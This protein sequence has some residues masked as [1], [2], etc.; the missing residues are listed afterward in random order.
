MKLTRRGFLGAAGTAT[1][2]V[3]ATGLTGVVPA[4]AADEG[5][6]AH[7]VQRAAVCPGCS[8]GCGVRCEVTDGLVSAVVGDEDH[9]LNQ[10]RHCAR[11]AALGD[12]YAVRSEETGD[13]TVNPA[14]LTTPRVRR[15]GAAA[16]EELDW[17][18]ALDEIADWMRSI[19]E[20]TFVEKEDKAV[21]NRCDGLASFGGA[22]LTCEEQYVLGKALRS[23][24]V[25]RLDSEASLDRAAGAYAA[26]ATVG[27]A[28]VAAPL[29]DCANAN[30]VLAL[31]AEVASHPALLPWIQKAQQ[32]GAPFIVVD[33]RYTPTAE[34][35]DLFCAIRPGTFTVFLNG[36]VNYVI[37]QDLWQHEYVINFTNAS[38]LLDDAYGF[39][40][41]SGL[42]AGWDAERGAYDTSTWRYAGN[43]TEPWST[44]LGGRHGWVRTAGVPSWKLPGVPV[45]ERDVTLRNPVSVWQ[46]LANHVSRYDVETVAK[47]CGAD[48]ALIEAVY[49]AY[50]A[51]GAPEQ[52]GSVVYGEGLVH[53]EGAVQAVRAVL[54]VQ[55]LLG[56]LGMA[57][58]AVHDVTGVANSQGALDLGLVP[59][60]LPGYLPEPTAATAS[61]KSWLEAHT[62]PD[63]EHAER[64]MPLVSLLKEWWGGAAS[65]GNDYGFAWLP[66]A[67]AGASQGLLS[68]MRAVSEG[69]V[70][71]LLAW[72]AN[73]ARLAGGA[74][75]TREALAALDVLVVADTAENETAAF[76][77]APNARAEAIDT[78]VYLLPTAA[79]WETDGTWVNGSRW[80]QY[81]QAVATAP[82]GVRSVGAIVDQLWVR[83]AQRYRDEGGTV[84]EPILQAKWDYRADDAFCP[85]KV[86]WA[87]NGYQVEGTSFEGDTVKL[88]RDPSEIAAD[89]TMACGAYIYSGSWNNIAG[90]S[91]FS[92]QPVGRREADDEGGLGL[93]DRWG[94]SWPRNVRVAENRASCDLS[95]TP[96]N[97]EKP[98]VAWE[99]GRW[100]QYDAAD[101]PTTG[102]AEVVAPSNRVFPGVWEQCGRLVA[103]GL[104]DGPLPEFYEPTETPV[105]VGVNGAA[106]APCLARGSEAAAQT[107]SEG[108]APLGA[109]LWFGTRETAGL[110]DERLS[111]SMVALAPENYV[112]MP[113]VVASPR[114]I[115]TGDLVRLRSARGEMTARAWV[116]SRV[117]VYACDGKEVPYVFV[118][119]PFGWHGALVSSAGGEEVA[120]S[121]GDAATEAPAWQTVTVEIEKA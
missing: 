49:A 19:R 87:L 25:T 50:G 6:G 108:E 104:P 86:S 89:G 107:G 114:S 93:F 67:S 77:S 113:T 54:L 73:P 20:D 71:G 56:N 84:P 119:A 79:P 38:Y 57:G 59:G 46:Q 9:P 65:V 105:R 55:Q 48:P 96:W 35:A 24:G 66:K 34:K 101:F 41:E 110:G 21:V 18:T 72:E 8:A 90:A 47:V 121:V 5:Q 78:T 14:R 100:L 37:Q 69:T 53:G 31:G 62:A 36:L 85:R 111:R 76:W 27:S 64:A 60:L 74:A 23:L 29:S 12:A 58:G 7:S 112:E 61:L 106:A 97:P 88:M 40:A 63:G 109:S 16:W 70:K 33:T 45:V 11:A 10:G 42:F 2:A 120:L 95:G 82:E 43:R 116:T 15:P 22:R 83:V 3:A 117:P 39:D 26:L 44:L 28:S 13:I 99:G 118:T 17:D 115:E 51:T 52:A 94:F 103:F 102:E 1:V 68:T 81:G 30:A 98:L 4:A 75:A 92:Q 91:D 32:A 80:M